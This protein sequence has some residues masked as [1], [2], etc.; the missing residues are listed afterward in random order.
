[1]SGFISEV[2]PQHR[3]EIRS[4]ATK[5]RRYFGPIGC[6]KPDRKRQWLD[7]HTNARRN[8]QEIGKTYFLVCE[9]IEEKSWF[10]D[11]AFG[12]GNPYPH[13]RIWFNLD[14]DLVFR[15]YVGRTLPNGDDTKNL[16]KTETTGS[17]QTHAAPTPI[18]VPVQP[19]LPKKGPYPKNNLNPLPKNQSSQTTF[20]MNQH[21]LP[22]PVPPN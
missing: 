17:Q 21:P 18:P 4:M 20:L 15:T 1:M 16:P 12:E 6:P 3:S 2:K 13:G 7:Y 14:H 10:G 11:F 5:Q 9:K 22:A 8:S 19:F